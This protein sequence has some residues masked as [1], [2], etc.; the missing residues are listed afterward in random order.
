[1]VLMKETPLSI[2]KLLPG[3]SDK[4][5]DN[6]TEILEIVKDMQKK[7]DDQGKL[8]T[9]VAMFVSKLYHDEQITK[10]HLI[11]WMS[12]SNRIMMIQTLER[13]IEKMNDTLKQE[14]K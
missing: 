2:N 14:S 4:G 8:L 1:M 6:T 13:I 9:K 10:K 3:L 11:L 12:F 7:L 5:S